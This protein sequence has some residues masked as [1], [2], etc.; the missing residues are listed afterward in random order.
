MKT[1]PFRKSGGNTEVDGYDLFTHRHNFAVW[2]AARAAQRGLDNGTNKT[3]KDALEKSG[4]VDYI[5][6]KGSSDINESDY[7]RVHRKWCGSIIETVKGCGSRKMSY[8][9]AA[10]LVGIYLKVMIVLSAEGN[11][12]LANVAHPPIDSDLL[13]NLAGCARIDGNTKK[14]LESVKWTRLGEEE[15]FS[16]IDTLRR[17]GYLKCPYWKLERYWMPNGESGD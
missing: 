13:K 9:R 14:Y 1:E 10:K 5:L 15:Y 7:D 17:L 8:G 2:A 6:E 16:L 4:I 3:L 11:T 12:W